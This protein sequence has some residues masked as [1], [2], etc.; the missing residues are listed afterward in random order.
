MPPSLTMY[1]VPWLSPL[2]RSPTSGSGP[3]SLGKDHQCSPCQAK[4]VD[5]VKQLADACVHD[6][7]HGVD[8]R[9]CRGESCG[10]VSCNQLLRRAERTVRCVMSEVQEKRFV[11]VSSDEINGPPRQPR[12]SDRDYRSPGIGPDHRA[13]T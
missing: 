5:L 3:L 9:S 2:K 10:K 7:D 8:R 13:G 4:S 11:A 6:F 12:P 1:F